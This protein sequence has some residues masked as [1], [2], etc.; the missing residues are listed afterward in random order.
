[1]GVC[2]TDACVCHTDSCVC[3]TDPCVCNTDSCV[4]AMWT[5]VRAIAVVF[6]FAKGE[7]VKMCKGEKVCSAVDL[8]HIPFTFLTFRVP[9]LTRHHRDSLV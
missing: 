3:D 5:R 6:P 2:N 8:G 1:M 4:C 7:E 9:F